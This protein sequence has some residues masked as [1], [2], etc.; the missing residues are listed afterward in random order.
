MRL[1]FS[2]LKRS[3]QVG[4]AVACHLGHNLR[5]VDEEEEGARLIR[6]SASDHRLACNTQK[7]RKVVSGENS[8]TDVANAVLA[9]HREPYKR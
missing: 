1:T 9:L 5:S 7:Q 6:H 3:S 8:N 2:L 4:L